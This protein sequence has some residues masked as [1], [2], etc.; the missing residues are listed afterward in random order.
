MTGQPQDPQAQ[1]QEMQRAQLYYESVAEKLHRAFDKNE[2]SVYDVQ[3]VF[4]TQHEDAKQII[5]TMHASGMIFKMPKKN[6]YVI[7][8]T[9]FK[10][11]Q[12]L[13][14][15]VAEMKSIHTTNILFCDMNLKL[16]AEA[17]AIAKEEYENRSKKNDNGKEDQTDRQ[18]DRS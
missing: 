12:A 6:K 8:A 11:L 17:T 5:D 18:E 1:D 15:H 16:L 9:H 4:G 7:S 14:D 2:F 3:N 13:V 10:S